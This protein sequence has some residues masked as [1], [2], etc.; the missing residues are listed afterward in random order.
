[1]TAVTLQVWRRQF[2]YHNILDMSVV[3]VE[4]NVF[5]TMKEIFLRTPR[6]LGLR[7]KQ[8]EGNRKFEEKSGSEPEMKRTVREE[9]A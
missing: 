9:R 7:P 5:V 2:L 6:P 1:M 3:I 8:V 4:T